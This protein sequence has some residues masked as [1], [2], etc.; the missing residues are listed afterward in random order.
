ML[1]PLIL[2]PR[3]MHSLSYGRIFESRQINE[4][5]LAYDIYLNG[6]DW[7]LLFSVHRHDG[8]PPETRQEKH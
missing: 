7:I 2:E 6:F 3:V 4:Y 8:A 1:T 5:T